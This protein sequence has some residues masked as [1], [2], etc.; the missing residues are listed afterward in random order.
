MSANPNV[1]SYGPEGSI[2]PPA[3]PYDQTS[4][5][6]KQI[7]EGY[8]ESSYG[9]TGPGT[10]YK[11]QRWS[12]L[13]NG[14]NQTPLPIIYIK[15][16]SNFHSYAKDNNYLIKV[17]VINTGSN[18]Y[19]GKVFDGTVNSSANVPNC[20]PNFFEKTKW[21]T[22]TLQGLWQG[23]PKYM[24][25]IH[26]EDLPQIGSKKFANNHYNNTN[27]LRE[28]RDTINHKKSGLS[29]EQLFWI[30]LSVFLGIPLL[31]LIIIFLVKMF[32]RG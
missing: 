16:D 21:Y 15:P 25:E 8:N 10:S 30:L 18:C 20:R 3:K 27:I 28:V 14:N 11:I 2:N 9:P 4:Y 7:K 17:K 23:F 5:E 31:I 6:F 24:G 12:G 19:D 1:K 22:I 26:L 13:I 29:S 32:K